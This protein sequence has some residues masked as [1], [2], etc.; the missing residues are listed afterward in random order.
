MS[1]KE[2]RA[3]VNERNTK[4]GAL[5]PILA[6][7]PEG[8]GLPAF[9]SSCNKVLLQPAPVQL[10]YKPNQRLVSCNPGAGVPRVPS[11]FVQTTAKNGYYIF[12][13]GGKNQ[14]NIFISGHVE[15][16]KFKVLLEHS[17]SHLFT[18]CFRSKGRTE[19]CYRNCITYKT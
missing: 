2:F 1:Y 3:T 14:K 12:R 7:S 16:M 9:Q 8:H 19:S 15:I 13:E 10:G 18:G 11:V 6:L 4:L 17:H 5:S